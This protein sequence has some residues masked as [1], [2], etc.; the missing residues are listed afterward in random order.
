MNQL[1]SGPFKGGLK[2]RKKRIVIDQHSVD[3]FRAVKDD[4]E[5]SW[6]C[7]NG[8]MVPVSSEFQYKNFYLNFSHLGQFWVIGDLGQSCAVFTRRWWVCRTGGRIG[9]ENCTRVM[10]K[11]WVSCSRSS[12]GTTR[13]SSF[14][15]RPPTLEPQSSSW[16]PIRTFWT[17]TTIWS[18]REG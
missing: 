10:T 5:K 13:T 8:G 11:N 4:Q 7:Q 9:S 14:R 15:R 3:G 16:R 17:I 1:F 12:W 2:N 6:G 18:R